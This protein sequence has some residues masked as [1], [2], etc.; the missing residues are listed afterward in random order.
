MYRDTKNVN[1]MSLSVTIR[2]TKI[3]TKVLKKHLE[4]TTGKHSSGII[5]KDSYAWK[6]SGNTGGTAVCSL[7]PERWVSRGKVP[8]RKGL[9]TSNKIIKIIILFVFLTCPF[10]TAIANDKNDKKEIKP[11]PHED[12]KTQSTQHNKQKQREIYKLFSA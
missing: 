8:A 10:E 12:T 1:H 3:V 9:V 5:T 6:I 4:T 7:E 11:R 2:A